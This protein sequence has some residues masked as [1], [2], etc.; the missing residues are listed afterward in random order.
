MATHGPPAI[1]HGYGVPQPYDDRH[2]FAAKTLPARATPHTLMHRY[3][4]VAPVPARSATQQLRHRVQPLQPSHVAQ[5]AQ[6]V[7]L[8]SMMPYKGDVKAG[9]IT[10]EQQSSTLAKKPMKRSADGSD[11]LLEAQEMQRLGEKE[12]A[13][14]QQTKVAEMQAKA[15]EDRLAQLE[16][17]KLRVDRM[18]DAVAAAIYDT[19]GQIVQEER[20]DNYPAEGQPYPMAAGGDVPYMPGMPS[21]GESPGMEYTESGMEQP[22]MEPGMPGAGGAGISPF[23]PVYEATPGSSELPP[24][25]P[26]MPSTVTEGVADMLQPTE[27]MP[28]APEMPAVLP[29]MPTA[30]PPA[31]ETG[32]MASVGATLM[33]NLF[34][35]TA[36]P[37]DDARSVVAALNNMVTEPADT[38]PNMIGQVMD[39]VHEHW[40]NMMAPSAQFMVKM[41]EW[42][43]CWVTVLPLVLLAT[44]LGLASRWQELAMTWFYNM[45]RPSAFMDPGLIRVGW[46]ISCLFEGYAFAC[47]LKCLRPK[48]FIHKVKCLMSQTDAK[49]WQGSEGMQA[50]NKGKAMIQNCSRNSKRVLG[51]L[52]WCLMQF[53]LFV[54][55]VKFCADQARA[56]AQFFL[57]LHTLAAI[58]THR[59]FY[60]LNPH[61]SMF[62]TFCCL[63]S[64]YCLWGLHQ[65]LNLNPVSPPI[66]VAE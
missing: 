38:S 52:S 49:I 56:P 40:Y 35:S 18:Q 31:M 54:L 19:A 5:P 17:E 41:R 32:G 64:L 2:R 48:S 42:H 8:R 13:L 62:T 9:S 36:P 3:A 61:T 47:V 60:K 50:W 30:M 1:T 53:V 26:S 34:G 66:V 28:A 11:L 24:M 39:T 44:L 33:N 63:W 59:A 57:L 7:Q 12:M 45:E 20:R 22:G 51:A 23:E 6:T 37:M 25:V 43:M 29:G 10:M 4:G 16:A 15:A 21:T 58:C 46:I 65:M 55:H 27:Y 14:E